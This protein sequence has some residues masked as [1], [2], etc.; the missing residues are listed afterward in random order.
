MEKRG[1]VE[2]GRW[3]SAAVGSRVSVCFTPLRQM[4][5]LAFPP[6][7]ALPSPPRSRSWAHPNGEERKP[8]QNETKSQCHQDMPTSRIPPLEKKTFAND[9]NCGT[10]FRK[11]IYPL[12]SDFF[13]NPHISEALVAGS[14]S[15]GHPF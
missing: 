4:S 2:E 14:L 1:E 10:L 13:R 3:G 11:P 15:K 5:F 7:L 6:S 8:K 9:K 12:K